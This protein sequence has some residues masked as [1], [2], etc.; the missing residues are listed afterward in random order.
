MLTQAWGGRDVTIKSAKL[1]PPFLNFINRRTS[2]REILSFSACHNKVPYT[3]SVVNVAQI[4]MPLQS[5][6]AAQYSWEQLMNWSF[7][8]SSWPYLACTLKGRFC[9]EQDGRLHAKSSLLRRDLMWWRDVWNDKVSSLV[10]HCIIRGY[11]MQ[12]WKN[13]ALQGSAQQLTLKFHMIVTSLSVLDL[14]AKPQGSC[15]EALRFWC[16]PDALHCVRA[17]CR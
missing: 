12:P 6:S 16:L 2:D 8:R 1:S 14:D 5:L 9:G 13:V 15:L 7:D 3:A 4:E 17:T 10:V 11:E